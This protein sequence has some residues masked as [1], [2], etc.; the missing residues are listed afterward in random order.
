GRIHRHG[1]GDSSITSLLYPLDGRWRTKRVE[2]LD[3][4]SKLLSSIFTLFFLA[5]P[6]WA[7]TNS[8]FEG[9]WNVALGAG[10]LPIHDRRQIDPMIEQRTTTTIIGSGTGDQGTL[11][12]NPNGTYTLRF[13]ES[14][15]VYGVP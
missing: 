15:V 5:L 1:T 9:T 14:E 4:M 8:Q 2:N 7:Q 12:I 13:W 6:A 10:V 3:C 11:E